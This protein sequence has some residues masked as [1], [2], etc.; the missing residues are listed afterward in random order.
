MHIEKKLQEFN[1]ID[2]NMFYIL[3]IIGVAIAIFDTLLAGMIFSRGASRNFIS[4]YVDIPYSIEIMLYILVFVLVIFSV[5]LQFNKNSNKGK[6]CFDESDIKVDEAIF[7]LKDRKINI[8]FNSVENKSVFKRSF[9]EGCN[10]W[11]EIIDNKEIQKKEFRIYSKQQEDELLSQLQAWQE[12][13]IAV[14]I[15]KVRLSFWQKWNEF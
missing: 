11:V 3:K 1:I 4:R 12:S 2:S 6:L 9:L 14:K 7:G 5:R 10:N 15:N 8:Y 13:G